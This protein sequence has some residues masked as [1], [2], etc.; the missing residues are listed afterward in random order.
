[1]IPVRFFSEFSMIP[2]TIFSSFYRI[3]ARLHSSIF[4]NNILE[5]VKWGIFAKKIYTFPT[6][7]FYHIFYKFT[8]YQLIIVVCAEFAHTTIISFSSIYSLRKFTTFSRTLQIFG[9]IFPPPPSCPKQKRKILT[10]THLQILQTAEVFHFRQLY[11]Q[12]V[13]RF[14]IF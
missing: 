7:L 10:T 4:S 1:M 14:D 5:Q 2:T 8:Y 12:N 11:C 3:P 13:S 6:A 9:N